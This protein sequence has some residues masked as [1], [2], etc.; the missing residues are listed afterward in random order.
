MNLKVHV[1]LCYSYSCN[2]IYILIL[3]LHKVGNGMG[4]KQGVEHA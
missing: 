1:N 2:S 4:M 3:F